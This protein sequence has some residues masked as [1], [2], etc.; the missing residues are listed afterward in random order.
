MN[1]GF[2]F[3]SKSIKAL[4]SALGIYLILSGIDAYCAVGAEKHHEPLREFIEK[5][6]WT[7]YHYCMNLLH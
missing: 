5:V 3:T 7:F 1:Q 6:W 4:I 2:S